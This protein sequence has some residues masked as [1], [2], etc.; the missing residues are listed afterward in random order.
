VR[1]RP[2][3][4]SPGMNVPVDSTGTLHI[5][6]YAR[7]GSD[8][9]RAVAAYTSLLDMARD[10]PT[11]YRGMEIPCC[12]YLAEIEAHFNHDPLKAVAWLERIVQLRSSEVT[13]G[14]PGNGGR[15]RGWTL[16]RNLARHEIALLQH[17]QPNWH[18]ALDEEEIYMLS[19][20]LLLDN[21]LLGMTDF[22]QSDHQSDSGPTLN[23]C[24]LRMAARSNVSRLDRAMAQYHLGAGTTEQAFVK[25]E[26]SYLKDLLAGDSFFAPAGGVGLACCQM[27]AGK[28][29]D[30]RETLQK[31]TARFPALKSDF[32]EKK[33]W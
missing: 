1:L 25:G 30:A 6:T 20:T 3:E 16:C 17:K 12:F 4:K 11:V 15:E 8:P 22:A 18:G 29:D 23:R 10:N 7:Y 19:M 24:L 14:E 31:L 13:L 2:K 28:A 5:G 26:P 32:D 27:K 9:K 21:G 33:L